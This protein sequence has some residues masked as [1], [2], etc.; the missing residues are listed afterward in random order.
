MRTKRFFFFLLFC[1]AINVHAQENKTLRTVL[2]EM[3]AFREKEFPADDNSNPL[4]RYR[5]EDFLRRGAFYQQE[6]DK[7]T[8]IQ[9]AN[10]S[11]ADKV[12]VALLKYQL[13]E[14][15]LP[16]K[17][18]AYLNPILSDEGFHTSVIYR[19]PRAI[20]TAKEAWHYL[21]LLKAIPAYFDEN[22]SL[23]Q[24]GLA[25]GISQPAVAL[26]GFEATYKTHLVDTVSQSVFWQPFNKKPASI[27]SEEW[28]RLKVEAEAAIRGSVIPAYRHLGDFFEKT[29][30]PTARKTLGVSAFPQGRDYYTE[31]VKFHTTTNITPDEVFA[32]GEKEVARIRKEMDSV[33]ALSG[34][35]G[36][37]KDFLQFLR[38][39]GRFYAT[40]PE[41]LLKEASFIAKKVDGQLPNLFG[42]LPRLSYGIEPVPA[43][44]APT[45]TSG[46][47]N[48]GPIYSGRAGIYWVNTYNLPSRTLYTLESL[49]LHEAAP[50]H[51]LQVSLAHELTNLPEFRKNGYV[52]AFGEGWG[53]Y[54]EYL[55][56]ELG[57]YKNP[58]SLFGRLT[59][60]MWRACRLVIDVG[61]H[62]KGWTREQAIQYLADNTA[63][64]LHEVNTEVARYI[65]WPGQALS[66]KIGELKIKSL[67]RKAEDELGAK[68]DLRSFHDLLLSEGSV[69]LSILEDMV[70][71]YIEKE[72]TDRAT[73]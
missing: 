21:A 54:S 64:S 51:L 68:F 13:S 12:N 19:L 8:A 15:I 27:T 2:A 3:K 23:M 56:Y 47:A 70:N 69:T 41:Q 14:E 37:F 4:G 50:G 49:T 35:Q 59:Y 48:T 24:K 44:L 60:E 20:Q 1:S 39:D 58:Y 40:T 67:R 29:Y 17:Y 72:R 11:A 31:L 36:S 45:Y 34:F 43:Y 22:I 55:G 73:K 5:E 33:I 10:I 53:L 30:Y 52:N 18:K 66:Y 6:Y 46:R 71:A 32:L 7:L 42:K 28:N 26:Q 16:V 61:I 38:T 25:L 57:L 9:P 65:A 63:L 62:W